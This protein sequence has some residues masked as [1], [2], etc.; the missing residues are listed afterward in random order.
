LGVGRAN[1]QFAV[2][3]I[4]VIKP[5][6]WIVQVSVFLFSLFGV[7]SRGTW[8][9]APVTSAKTPELYFYALPSKQLFS[10]G[11]RVVIVLQL[12][13]RSEQ[14]ILVSRLQGDEFVSFKVIG[15]D[16]KEVARQSEALAASKGHSPL[17]FHCF[18]AI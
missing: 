6:R 16:G 7:S 3:N 1:D 5:N 9:Q 8:G 12:Y 18:G 2:S 13:S 11:E 10:L 14:P 4:S 17:R 15:P